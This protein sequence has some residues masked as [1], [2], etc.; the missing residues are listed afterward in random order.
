MSGIPL[1]SERFIGDSVGLAADGDLAARAGADACLL[2]I[3]P[4]KPEA[5]PAGA[6]APGVPQK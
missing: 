3:L 4:F 6:A 5:K 1:G 2:K